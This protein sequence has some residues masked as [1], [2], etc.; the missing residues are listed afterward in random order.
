MRTYKRLRTNQTMA[1]NQDHE[2]NQNVTENVNIPEAENQPENENVAENVAKAD[3]LAVVSYVPQNEKH[4]EQIVNVVQNEHASESEDLDQYL[5]YPRNTW[6]YDITITVHCKLKFID[7]IKKVLDVQSE[8]AGFKK[9]C[10][11]H[12]LGLPEYM[13]GLLVHT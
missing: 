6:A 4:I 11:G 13:R 2:K 7:D 8:L 5:V 12:Y 1:E 10:F 9:G 3:N